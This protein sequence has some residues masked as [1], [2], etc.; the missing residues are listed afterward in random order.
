M[1]LLLIICGGISAYK[2]LDLIRDL[3][4]NYSFNIETV[5]TESAENFITPL[6]I[7]SLSEGNVFDR[8][9]FF[10]QKNKILHIDISRRND[11]ILVFSATANFL[12]KVANGIC[13]DL[14]TT[15]VI[16]SGQKVV[17]APAMNPE[18]WN[19]PAIQRNIESLGKDGHK[20]VPPDNGLTACNELGQG[21]LA[22]VSKIKE[23]VL[24][25]V[26]QRDTLLNKNILITSGPTWESIDP[27]R[28]IT[29]KS[30][31]KQ[32]FYLYRAFE[33]AGANVS[34][35]AGGNHVGLEEME[36][37]IRVQSAQ[38]MHDRFMGSIER[39]RIDVAI[40]V[41]AVADWK[42][43]NPENK[44]I[45]KSKNKFSIELIPTI[46]ILKEIGNSSKKP[47]ILIGFAAETNDIDEN[48]RKK[49]EEKNA[50]LIISNDVSNGQVFNSDYNTVTLFEKMGRKLVYKEMEKEQ[51]SKIIL[52]WVEERLTNKD[53][54]NEQNEEK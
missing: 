34:I 35:I 27:V 21:R 51:V 29:N 20:I 13:D 33:R 50:D 39:N 36:N 5:L 18:M 14:A 23:S 11:V 44:K 4:L 25:R 15:I 43:E 17:F 10:E 31:G 9:S 1:N 41:A 12:S 48:V 22:S 52:D 54:K 32:G 37:V 28:G 42:I 30:S 3:K 53:Q 8:N 6:A 19:Y 49:L 7:S 40:C 26:F 16:A 47:P 45:K 38:E 46:D 2:S 24:K